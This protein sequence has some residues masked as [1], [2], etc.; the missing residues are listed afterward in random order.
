MTDLAELGLRVESREVEAAADRLEGLGESAGR[1]EWASDALGAA[2]K[3][4]TKLLGQLGLA[5]TLAATTMAA[6]EFSASMR[7]VSTLVDT[8]VFSM[9]D[10][11]KAAIDQAGAFNSAPITQTKALYQIISAGASS[12]AQATDTLTA[13]NMLAV[14]G[15]TSVE[16]AADGLTG[17][18]N[19][20]GSKVAGAA[21]VSDTLFIGLKAGKTTIGELSASLG[22]VLPLAAA[23]GVSFDELVAATSALTK[24][25]IETSVAVNGL[26]S[27]LAAVAKPSDEAAKLAAKLGL[28][29]NS[30]ALESK[31]LAGFLADL[32]AKTGGNTDALAKLFGGLEALV[33]VMA[34]SGQAG[35]DF[36]SILD[37]MTGKAGATQEAFDKIASGPAFQLGRIFATLTANAIGAAAAFADYLAPAI[38]TTAD[39][40]TGTTKPAL[41]LQILLNALGI[42]A[43]VILA[44]QLYGLAAAVVA[45]TVAAIT[46]TAAWRAYMLSVAL[47]G[48]AAAT[49]TVAT[50]ALGVA[51]R[52]MLGPIGLAITAI[53]LLATGMAMSSRE[54]QAQK[55][56]A[57]GTKTAL[58]EYEAAAL[59]A[60]TASG[61]GAEKAREH[62]NAMRQEALD[63][64]NAARALRE[65]A[66]AQLGD[67][68]ART[69]DPFIGQRN[70]NPMG[71]PDADPLVVSRR[72]ALTQATED[73][74]AAEKRYASILSG[75]SLP[76]LAAAADTSKVKIDLDEA[77]AKAA[78]DSGDTLFEEAKRL[79][80]ANDA[81]TRS[82]R[83][84]LDA[85]AAATT[86][87]RDSI[88]VI[89]LE[90]DMIGASARDREIAI[91]G[92]RAEQEARARGWQPDEAAAYVK[93]Q[94][95]LAGAT[96]DLRVEQDAYNETL[97]STADALADIDA[98]AQDAASG[99]ASAFGKTGKALGDLLTLMTRYNARQAEMTVRRKADGVTAE[100][101]AR[102]D[103]EAARDKVNLYGD[104]I[105]A[106]KGYFEEGSK[107]YKALQTA[108]QIYRAFEFAMAVKAMV[109]KTTETG[110]KVAAE[111]TGVAAHG[112]AATAHVALD[113]TTTASGIAAGAARIF[114]TLGP[115]GFPVVAAMVAVMAGVGAAVMGGGSGAV[116]G[117]N[118]MADRQRLQG[119]G[120]VLGD[121]NAKSESIA[122]SLKLVAANTNRDLEYSNAMLR[123]LRSI[124]DQIGMVAAALARS[125]GAGG[126]LDTSKLGLGTTT[127]GPGG[128]TRALIPLSN[129]LP[130]LFGTTRST[131]LQD[132]GVQFGSGSL[133]D[134]L[135]GGLT[136]SA[137]QQ[138]ATQTK[139]KFFGMTYSDKTKTSTTTSGLDGDFLRQTELLI[140]SLRDGV[141]AAA[142]VLGVEGAA[143]TLAAFQVNLGKLSFKD[144]SGAE[145]QAALEGVFGKLADDMA[146][147]VLPGLTDLQKVGEGLFETLTRV[148]R[149]YQVVDITLSS[150]GK[151]F[152]AV[153][154]SSLMARE[155]LIDLFG[156][157]DDFTDQVSFYSETY[158]SEAER[159]APVQSAVTA[160]L[161]RLGLAG[162]KTRDQ[163]R[164]VVQG[165]DVSTE[166]GSQ[167]FAALMALAP[168]FA[169]VTEETQAVADARDALSGAY[170]RESDALNDTLDRFTSYAADLKKFREGLYSGPAA[171]LSP[172]AQYL[173]NKAEFERVSGLATAGNE[174][175]LGELQGVS[176]AYL[177]ASKA[178]YAS[179]AGYFADLA[180]VRD[181]VTAA[182]AV[183]GAQVGVA[184]QQ[185]QALKDLVSPLIS[186]DES[187][188]TVADAIVA[189]NTALGVPSPG[190]PA[191]PGVANDN[192][193][194]LAALQQTNAL[195]AEQNAQQA[196][197]IANQQAQINQQAAIFEAE[198]TDMRE[199]TDLLGRQLRETQAV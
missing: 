119:T 82:E 91:A 111:A 126:M 163:F 174:Q 60:A 173:A 127:S 123:A 26:R 7:E 124:D 40:I 137:Y 155:R 172:E 47:V 95:R 33:P 52:F 148:A 34:L 106:A 198:Q 16:V 116:P 38:K 77:A 147:A 30:A 129:F 178:Y 64:V 10:L 175:A 90:R 18:L 93:E 87:A 133:E 139:K 49:A 46:G 157:L 83:D 197:V 188:V 94:R 114:A 4:L 1:A 21:A 53:G 130:G 29:F 118:D 135:S 151:T 170:G 183:A 31:G 8:S 97:W 191:A 66:I 142:G 128:L 199:Q 24:G 159:L 96:H 112:A 132:Q 108:E 136:G 121:A 160:E 98:R 73:A 3:E 70:T 104:M 99:M 138:V 110:V 79:K 100:E 55:S 109:M 187:L 11:T 58:D 192:T 78:K 54:M 45:N 5:G 117:D 20:Y 161:T 168:A 140:G 27:V 65:K 190:V 85:I 169:K 13:A 72:A 194:L 131:T 184:E 145:I 81:F 195:L 2:V 25:E 134:I 39:L 177:D 150:I 9:R 32:Q 101:V 165:L 92:L 107:G 61:Q 76:A 22:A 103:Q 44:K 176:Q 67:A 63:A 50:T 180:V 143:A 196:Q 68:V 51:V 28:E 36:A 41:A 156:S 181:A 42:T 57:L 17:V 185:L 74:A 125:F 71:N 59:A 86:S 144:M 88:A 14:G 6:L 19:A 154:V 153:G 89:S 167:L 62:A 171:A 80:D 120:S 105:G 15:V 158:L 23:M 84:R 141:L 35:K 12:A 166:A 43:G 164:G 152:G 75:E 56:A 146:G 186:I 69:S 179:S 193:D 48:P 122:N 149:Q 115:F 102:I 37:Q 113:A 182:E 162:I 189:L